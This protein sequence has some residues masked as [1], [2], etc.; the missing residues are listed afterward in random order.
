MTASWLD[1]ESPANR[2]REQVLLDRLSPHTVR[3]GERLAHHVSY[4][5]GGPA[6]VF[7]LPTTTREACTA[8]RTCRQLEIPLRV[9]G[10]GSNV[11]PAAA[12]F[13][14]AVLS[15]RSLNGLR[16]LPAPDGMGV[17]ILRVGAGVNL[18]RLIRHAERTGLAGLEKLSG[19]PG[20][21]GGAVTMNTGG[22]PGAPCI[23]DH[24]RGALV[25]D[26]AEYKPRYLPVDQ[27]R[28]RY[29]GSRVL[30]EGMLL[31]EVDLLLTKAD[32]LEIRRRIV[33]ATERKRAN[34][35]VWCHSAGCTFRNPAPPLP[36]AGALIDKAGLKGLRRGGVSVSEFHA[37]FIVNDKCGSASD[38][39]EVIDEVRE[40]VAARFGIWLQLEVRPL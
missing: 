15:T 19:I 21:V 25:L 35:P 34:Q 30:D 39:L 13:D 16:H 33:E 31:L 6:R 10:G 28:P 7:L 22:G 27:I 40:Q 17:E 12:G 37:N 14:G 3:F 9:L 18:M 38:V 29:R 23:G 5:V 36:S 11:L 4:R 24:V 8:A 1:R 26:P 32:P 20:T 2:V